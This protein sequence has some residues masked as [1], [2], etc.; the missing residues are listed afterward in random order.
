[1]Y[2]NMVT[3]KIEKHMKR[4]VTHL[5]KITSFQYRKRHFTLYANFP[6]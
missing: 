1:M 5:E 2:D 4:F 3:D 6:F